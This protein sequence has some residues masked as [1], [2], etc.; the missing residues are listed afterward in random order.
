MGKHGCP[1]RVNRAVSGAKVG[2]DRQKPGSLD[3]GYGTK[4]EKTFLIHNDCVSKKT[5]FTS[6]GN[7]CIRSTHGLPEDGG[8]KR[9][10]LRSDQLSG[11][12]RLA[13]HAETLQ[14]A[15]SIPSRPS[16]VDVW[17]QS[18]LFLLIHPH[19]LRCQTSGPEFHSQAP[20]ALGTQS[21]KPRVRSTNP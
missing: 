3:L 17:Y 4:K 14:L 6:S 5:S 10:F 7:V 12:K 13:S 2:E 20:C 15:M 1:W 11:Q 8:P 9:I 19:F 16:Q 18:R 21:Q